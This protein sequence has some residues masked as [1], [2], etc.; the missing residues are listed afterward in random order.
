M[1][2]GIKFFIVS[3]AICFTLSVFVTAVLLG[4]L[5]S[6]V[7]NLSRASSDQPAKQLY[8][9]R[10]GSMISLGT[11]IRWQYMLLA[12]GLICLLLWVS[13]KALSPY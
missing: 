6:L 9:Y 12:A 10:I 3:A 7:D 5:P 11:L 4:S 2:G 1:S 8:Q 13:I